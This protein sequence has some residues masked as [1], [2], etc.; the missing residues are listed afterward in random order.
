MEELSYPLTNYSKNL[1]VNGRN[2]KLNICGCLSRHLSMSFCLRNIFYEYF[3]NTCSYNVSVLNSP[4]TQFEKKV[5][6][7]LVLIRYL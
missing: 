4:V 2:Y 6:R 3:F 7:G 5:N 1:K